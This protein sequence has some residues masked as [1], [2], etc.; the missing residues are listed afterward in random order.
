VGRNLVH[1]AAV[2]CDLNHPCRLADRIAA[3]QGS[4]VPARMGPIVNPYGSG[5]GPPGRPKWP[6]GC[7][8]DYTSCNET[9][10]GRR[11]ARSGQSMERTR[12]FTRAR[13]TVT[14][15]IQPS[16]GAS[17]S[18]I[19]S[20]RERVPLA[21]RATTKLY[22]KFSELTGQAE[23]YRRRRWRLW[24]RALWT[25]GLR[26]SQTCRARARIAS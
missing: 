23:R 15:T 7:E 6:S 8:Q 14:A 11:P 12:A 24:W 2:T 1:C 16:S 3:G 22:L 17:P 10:A 5:R 9:S 19:I 20:S 18:C 4:R 13:P 21:P 25:Y 26:S